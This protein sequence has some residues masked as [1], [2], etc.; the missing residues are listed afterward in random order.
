MAAY[1]GGVSWRRIVAAC[2]A[3]VGFHRHIGKGGSGPRV[4]GT[5]T[6]LKIN[7]QFAKRSSRLRIQLHPPHPWPLAVR[8]VP[9][10]NR[11]QIVSTP[12][13]TLLFFTN[14]GFRAGMANAIRFIRAPL[15]ALAFAS[16]YSRPGISSVNSI[17][18]VKIGNYTVTRVSCRL[19]P[20][21]SLRFIRPRDPRIAIAPPITG[22]IHHRPLEFQ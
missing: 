5:A 13:A 8:R 18:I 11:D 7:M 1:R 2:R 12:A 6:P 9:L 10:L 22:V 4:D 17:C 3:G 15:V 20:F 19:D 21:V 16:G 14:I